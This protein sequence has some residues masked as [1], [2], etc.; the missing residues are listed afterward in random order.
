MHIKIF[1]CLISIGIGFLI[2]INAPRDEGTTTKE[3]VEKPKTRVVEVEKI[4]YRDV[5]P[6]ELKASAIEPE[7]K[8]TPSKT[9]EKL[10][11][12]GNAESVKI[13]EI[14]GDYNEDRGTYSDF[15]REI[16]KKRIEGK[17][18]TISQKADEWITISRN[19][20]TFPSTVHELNFAISYCNFSKEFLGI[21]VSKYGITW[22]EYA[23]FTLESN[24]FG[25]R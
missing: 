19:L 24:I 22:K 12:S 13:R 20:M 7:I 10:F 17:N 25:G 4:I 14:M 21:L 18:L 1:L 5:R 9:E 11:T 2:G 3:S 16:Y 6:P 23:K 8:A 15:I